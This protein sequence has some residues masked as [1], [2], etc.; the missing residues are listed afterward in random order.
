MQNKKSLY[1]IGFAIVVIA[2]VFFLKKTPTADLS[3]SP[4]TEVATTTPAQTDVNDGRY[5][6]PNYAFS[7]IPPKGFTVSSFGD[8]DQSGTPVTTV[9]IQEESLYK[10][11]AQ[12]LISAWDERESA[13]TPERI[14]HDIPSMHMEDV[15]TR[16][17][18]NIGTVVEFTSDNP[19]FAG[20]SR[21][22][23]FVAHDDL[24]Q[25]STYAENEALV[26]GILST[27]DFQ[28]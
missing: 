14:H 17:I 26:D 8:T 2:G 1:I 23:W 16:N 5:I 20:K 6:N 9:L 4:K 28:Q 15:S 18:V 12:I 21:E 13:L 10:K 22:I 19:D 25:M 11:G 24:Y 7:F 27:W 3:F